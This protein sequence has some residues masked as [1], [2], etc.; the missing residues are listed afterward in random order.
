LRWL[1]YGVK[2]NGAEIKYGSAFPVAL[3]PRAVVPLQN[4][5]GVQ[6]RISAI[7]GIKKPAAIGRSCPCPWDCKAL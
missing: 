6:N 5:T 2:F 3:H 1:P 7:A 4:Y